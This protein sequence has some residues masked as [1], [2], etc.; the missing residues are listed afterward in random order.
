MSN[1]TLPSISSQGSLQKYLSSIRGFPIL[2]KEEEYTLAKIWKNKKDL[3]AAHK[4]VTSHRRL[5]AKIGMG[6]KGY[7]LPVADLIS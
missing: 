6:Y 5:V 1:I 7:G 3:N 4:L 2:E